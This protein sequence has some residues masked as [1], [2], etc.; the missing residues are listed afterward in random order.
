M[1]DIYIEEDII[2]HSHGNILGSTLKT[3]TKT[4]KPNTKEVEM[5][6]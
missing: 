6:L 1:R 3:I 2:I 5:L 4:T